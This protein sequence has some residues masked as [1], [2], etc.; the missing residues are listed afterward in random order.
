MLKVCRP[1]RFTYIYVSAVTIMM[2]I[3]HI[4]VECEKC[5]AVYDSR[6][7]NQRH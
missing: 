4:I 5:D 7:V 2:R 3:L 6:A 1:T